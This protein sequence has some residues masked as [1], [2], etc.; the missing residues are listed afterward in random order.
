M[1]KSSTLVVLSALLVLYG[2]RAKSNQHDAT[3]PPASSPATIAPTNVSFSEAETRSWQDAW[4]KGK[5]V[6]VPEW[7]G[8]YTQLGWPDEL[9]DGL[10]EQWAKRSQLFGFSI[11]DTSKTFGK[12]TATA[13]NESVNK[14]LW[15]YPAYSISFYGGRCDG[16]VPRSTN[17]ER[18][19][20]QPDL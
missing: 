9:D 2:C 12:P 18:W 16:V 17:F 15:L 10:P 7:A 13:T 1:S 4:A 19:F 14:L 8:G 5:T 20:A 11:E 6:R 3:S